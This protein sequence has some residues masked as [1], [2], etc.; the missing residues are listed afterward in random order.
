MKIIKDGKIPSTVKRFKCTRCGCVFEADKG[1]YK[2]EIYFE[3]K[4]FY[5]KCP[6]CKEDTIHDITKFSKE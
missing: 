2:S 5:C 3:G 6:C 4:I 1:E